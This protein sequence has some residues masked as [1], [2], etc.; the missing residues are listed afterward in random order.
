MPECFP[1]ESH[2]IRPALPTLPEAALSSNSS[3]TRPPAL[4]LPPRTGTT[5][6]APQPVSAL[7]PTARTEPKHTYLVCKLTSF[8]GN[9][10]FPGNIKKSLYV[11]PPFFL[12]SINSC[13]ANPS[14]R[15][16][17]SRYATASAVLRVWAAPLAGREGAPFP[18]WVPAVVPF[19]DIFFFL[20][21]GRVG[22][23][24]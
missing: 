15:E 13:T 9:V 20:V 1:I 21:C 23:R 6:I 19:A 5:S 3:L 18:N 22:I 7:S 17:C 4:L 10:I 14:P 12:L 8:A 2:S 11:N 24:V 16:Y